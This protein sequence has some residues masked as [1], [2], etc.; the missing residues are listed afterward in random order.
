MSSSS[1]S[2]ASSNKLILYSFWQSS[3]AWRVRFALNV[4]GLSYEY[5]AVNL[6]KGEHLTPEFEKLNPLHYVP[7]VVDGDVVVS[8]SF[9]IL[10]YLED[11]YPGKA[12]LPVD[13]QLKA[14]NLQAASIVSS[15]IQ[16]L[17]MM[18]LLKHVQEK[19]GSEEMLSWAQFHIEKGF[20]ALEKLLKNVAGKF[21]TGNEVY[22]AD[23]FLAPQIAAASKRFNIDMSKYPTL[24]K[25]LESCMALPEFEA[26]MPHRQPDAEP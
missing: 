7:V 11:K 25:I 15:S 12:L 3:C 23:V 10:L 9:A 13:P 18:G 4:K 19:L 20:L 1:S 21:A 2:S 17:H 6:P 14:I 5:R 24:S 8:D 26:S 22:L 16:P